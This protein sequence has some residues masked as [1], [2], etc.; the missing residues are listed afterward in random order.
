MN[1]IKIAAI[2][3]F[4]PW[5]AISAG[6]PVPLGDID[7]Q[8]EVTALP[9]IEVEKPQG[10]WY[11]NIKLNNSPEDHKVY[12]SEFPITIK[13]RQQTGFRISVKNPLILTRQSNNAAV[14]EL[15]FSPAQVYWGKERT[16][17]QPLS[18][19]PEIFTVDE[20]TSSLTSTDY[21]LRISALAPNHPNSA[22]KYHG[23]LT[24]IFETNS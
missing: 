22:G 4:F 17:L 16:L 19:T 15:A 5:L 2:S 1:M 9:R 21:I 18:A 3:L 10:G 6:I 8:L 14:Q 23:Q 24:L 13:L 7:V 12:Q 11:D 20:G